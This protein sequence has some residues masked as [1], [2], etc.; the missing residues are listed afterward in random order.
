MRTLG[1]RVGMFSI[2]ALG[3]CVGIGS[4]LALGQSELCGARVLI[5]L[6]CAKK[7]PRDGFGEFNAKKE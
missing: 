3:H 5:E 4:L 6:F 2:F 7:N 1:H